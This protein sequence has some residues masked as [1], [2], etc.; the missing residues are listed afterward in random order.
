V[1]VLL[2]GDPLMAATK[3]GDGPK[4]RE[5]EALLRACLP[6]SV[7]ELRRLARERNIGWRSLQRAKARLAVVTTQPAQRRYAW[8]FDGTT[9]AA[10]VLSP[11][12]LGR[13][14]LAADLASHSRGQ[15]L[16]RIAALQALVAELVR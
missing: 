15:L 7:T 2:A 10:Q 9:T 11:A 6:C 12:E 13:R 14:A 3:D 1:A 8:S 4:V 5:A 16:D